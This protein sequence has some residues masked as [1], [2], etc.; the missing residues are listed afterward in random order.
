[1][2]PPITEDVLAAFFTAEPDPDQPV[3]FALT[4][5]AEAALDAAEPEPEAEL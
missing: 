4:E 3:P 1:M 2:N 5:E